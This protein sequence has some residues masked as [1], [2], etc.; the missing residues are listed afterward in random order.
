MKVENRLTMQLRSKTEL[1]Y[2]KAISNFY[3]TV[4]F[5][6]FQRTVWGMHVDWKLQKFS[7]RD[8]C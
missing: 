5:P 1:K 4:L 6:N 8:D 2:S 3:L 7:F